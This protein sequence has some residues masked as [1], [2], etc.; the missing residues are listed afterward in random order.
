MIIDDIVRYFG[1][2]FVDGGLLK[3]HGKLMLSPRKF[4]IAF[5]S[6]LPVQRHVM[7]FSDKIIHIND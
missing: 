2:K 6:I 3:E 1:Q 4:V 5:A 7:S